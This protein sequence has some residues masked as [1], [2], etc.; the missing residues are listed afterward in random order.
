MTVQIQ[1]GTVFSARPVSQA[2]R[3]LMLHHLAVARRPWTASS[4][5]VGGESGRSSASLV[6]LKRKVLA[7]W[8][9]PALA[10]FNGK[11]GFSWGVKEI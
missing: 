9:G 3:Y 8:P 5:F 10:V 4:V 2:P 11:S 1:Q 7:S 6:C